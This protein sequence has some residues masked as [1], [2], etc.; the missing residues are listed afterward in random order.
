VLYGGL[1]A[2]W[3]ADYPPTRN[4]DHF[5]LEIML[6]LLEDGSLYP[7]DL[8][9]HE[10]DFVSRYGPL[11][12]QASL[13]LTTWR[14]SFADTWPIW[15][16]LLTFLYLTGMSAALW[17]LLGRA[18]LAFLCA[19]LTSLP[20][21][22]QVS[23]AA[24]G[25]ASFYAHLTV[26]ALAG[27]ALWGLGKILE[28]RR[29]S[30][31]ALWLGLFVGLTF[32]LN[33]VNAGGLLAVMGLPFWAEKKGRRAFFFYMGSASLTLL[34]M[35]ALYVSSG[36]T[37]ETSAPS[38]AEQA[39]RIML[40]YWGTRLFP[41]GGQA[42]LVWGLCVALIASLPIYLFYLG[43]AN[44]PRWA[45]ILYLSLHS[46]PALWLI[47]V[48]MV[49][50][51]PLYGLF[52]YDPRD[53]WDRRLLGMLS[54]SN[55]GGLVL[56]ALGHTLWID[57]GQHAFLTLG[58]EPI[59]LLQWALLPTWIYMARWAGAGLRIGNIWG[60]LLALSIGATCLSILG[61][62]NPLKDEGVF[63]KA[64]LPSRWGWP[65]FVAGLAFWLRRGRPFPQLGAWLG[66]GGFTLLTLLTFASMSPLAGLSLWGGLLGIIFLMIA[67]NLYYRALSA[68]Y[69]PHHALVLVG[70][71]TLLIFA[72]VAGYH[73]AKPNYN[74]CALPYLTQCVPED[75][76]EAMGRWIQANTPREAQLFVLGLQ[77]ERF[78]PLARRSTLHVNR[79]QLYWWG[80]AEAFLAA[81]PHEEALSRAYSNPEA[82]N[83]VDQLIR[84]GADYL[85][86]FGTDS[87]TF[88]LPLVYER[89][90]ARLYHLPQE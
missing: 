12:M 82:P 61:A 32:Y 19:L 54:A 10:S 22:V 53:A 9:W 1:H 26:T 20:I 86:V 17:R 68:H 44:A 52:Q 89:P 60:M 73:R 88:D 5:N 18:D 72:P 43:R 39:R 45:H 70:A 66:G 75:K 40:A 58:Y 49:A 28:G 80:G 62:G 81:L 77:P 6:T 34:P 30:W 23:F 11:F 46:L 24:W 42:E 55:L 64:F 2:A 38:L 63:L 13:A 15:T 14:G 65:L 41:F 47:G 71:L 33:P 48:P 56:S 7:K 57:L 35:L 29:Q 37:S 16:F 84:L 78:Q 67:G 69:R 27:W 87:P 74:P 79:A 83:F 59:R 36:A 50:L 4:D 31:G 3:V 21:Y 90:Y 8:V 25:L 76:I 51:L 85:V